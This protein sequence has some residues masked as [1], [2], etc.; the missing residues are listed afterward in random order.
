M[1]HLSTIV[2]SFIFLAAFEFPNFFAESYDDVGAEVC[3][4]ACH[5]EMQWRENCAAKKECDSMAADARL[6]CLD[7]C[8]QEAV[9][10]QMACWDNYSTITAVCRDRCGS[11]N[12][13]DNCCKACFLDRFGRLKTA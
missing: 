1:G 2:L 12:D 6:T 9:R 3:A 10:C 8:L 11:D 7:S 5:V 4:E 13:S